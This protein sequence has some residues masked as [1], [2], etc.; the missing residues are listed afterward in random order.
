MSA[1]APAQG[2]LTVLGGGAP[3]CAANPGLTPSSRRTLPETG[4]LS[5]GL[6]TGTCCPFVVPTKRLSTP[7]TVALPAP[8]YL[9]VK[10]MLSLRHQGEESRSLADVHSTVG[11]SQVSFWKRMFAFAG[12]R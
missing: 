2:C 5:Q 7:R 8:T 6:P 4:C 10:F 12:D 11:T 9:I 3:K 1:R